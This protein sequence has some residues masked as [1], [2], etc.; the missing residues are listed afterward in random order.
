[1]AA[2]A[3]RSWHFKRDGKD[4]GFKQMNTED[5]LQNISSNIFSD[6]FPSYK[7]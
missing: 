2:F 1:M 3:P 5:R 4:R 7:P 6:N